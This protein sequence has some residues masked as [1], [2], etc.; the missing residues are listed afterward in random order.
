[1]KNNQDKPQ[2]YRFVF[3]NDDTHPVSAAAVL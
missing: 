1:V 3:A 2:V